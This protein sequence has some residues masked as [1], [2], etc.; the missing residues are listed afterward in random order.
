MGN[1]YFW[2]YIG[3]GDGFFEFVDIMLFVF[4]NSS[5]AIDDF[6]NDGFEDIVLL[7]K[8]DLER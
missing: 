2:F 1:V 7:G 3:N 4:F 8:V 5:V 6:N